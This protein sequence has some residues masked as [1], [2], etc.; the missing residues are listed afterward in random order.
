MSEPCA[1]FPDEASFKTI[2]VYCDDCKSG[3]RNDV[4]PC[5]LAY[6]RWEKRLNIGTNRD[7]YHLVS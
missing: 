5:W 3:H 7:Q 4:A 2:A 1:P 6:L